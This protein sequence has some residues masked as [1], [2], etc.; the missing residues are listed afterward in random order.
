VA[1]E[2]TRRQQVARLRRV[3]LEALERY[4]VVDARLSFVAHG[5]NTTFR[6]DALDTASREPSTFLLRV[7]RPNRHGRRVDSAAAI[8][9]E[10]QWLAA[11]RADTD[12]SVP[13]PVATL[14]G[15]LVCRAGDAHDLDGGPRCCSLLRWMDGRRRTDSARPVHLRRLGRA[16]AR[17]HDHGDHWTPPDDF[18]RI[19][20]DRTTFF[21]DVME[22]G[23]LPASEVWDLV[24]AGL[25]ERFDEVADRVGGLM[26]GLGTRSDVFGL[27]HADL[28]LYNALFSGG[29]VRMIDFD[30]CGPGFRIYD[31]AV[32]LWEL[33]HREDY[34]RFRDALLEGYT[35]QRPLPAEQV[36]LTDAFIA[37]RE[38]AF[39]LWFVGTARV[40]PAFGEKLD[41]ELGFVGSSLDRLL[42]AVR[43]LSP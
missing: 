37:A 5:E 23:G 30:D 31:V 4:P 39:G 6:V 27:I 7:H 8:R 34:G 10:L 21:G 43:L 41:E 28:H 32:A 19:T 36:A 29:D 12:L 3:A 42:P 40:N 26:D 25:R 11:I 22:Y 17:L 24:P 13:E 18:V 1:T 2:P 33:R 20:W 14:D 9:S 38:V 16:M 15:A 35:A